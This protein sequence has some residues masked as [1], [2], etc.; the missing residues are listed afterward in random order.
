MTW[1]DFDEETALERDTLQRSLPLVPLSSSG[2]ADAVIDMATGH[3]HVGLR[4]SETLGAT[5]SGCVELLG[6]RPLLVSAAWKVIDLLL[7]AAYE[8]AGLPPDLGRRWS[9]EGKAKLASVAAARPAVIDDRPWQALTRTYVETIEIRHSLVHRRAGLDGGKALV[10]VRADGTPLRPLTAAEQE[11]FARAALRVAELVLGASRATRVQADL[12]R[13]LGHLIALHG[14]SLP[15]VALRDAMPGITVIVYPQSSTE[16]TEPHQAVGYAIDLRRVRE[17]F[18]G[19]QYA[20]L[21]VRISDRPGADL[22]GNL[23]DAPADD[24]IIIEPEHPPGWLT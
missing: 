19:A 16:I 8:M 2:D 12:A 22:H 15:P 20:D 24:V 13:Q 1:Q 21:T 3:A 11:A 10:G 23:E 9:I 14:I 5:P 18:G 6:I 7:E 17:V 4:V